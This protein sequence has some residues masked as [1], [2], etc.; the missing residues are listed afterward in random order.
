MQRDGAGGLSEGKLLHCGPAFIVGYFVS[1]TPSRCLEPV[2]R[3]LKQIDYTW[4]CANYESSIISC[5]CGLE[6][7]GRG[8]ARVLSLSEMA[9]AGLCSYS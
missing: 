2:D 5:P 4:P 9:E 1:R 3:W 8:S 6:S 7:P